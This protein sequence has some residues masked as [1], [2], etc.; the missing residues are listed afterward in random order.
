MT[1]RAGEL[2]AS[3]S[4]GAARARRTP[5][6]LAAAGAGRA[7]R[8]AYGRSLAADGAGAALVLGA[9]LSLWTAFLVAVW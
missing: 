9:S 2:I 8:F 6:P 7:V 4:W 3:P 5:P 1:S